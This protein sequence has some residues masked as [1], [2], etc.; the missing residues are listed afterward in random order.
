VPRRACPGLLDEGIELRAQQF[1]VGADDGEEL[2]VN[3]RLWSFNHRP[4][5]DHRQ[6]LA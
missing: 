1:L 3:G 2:L 6:C 4:H 5:V